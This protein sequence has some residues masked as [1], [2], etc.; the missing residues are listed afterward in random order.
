MPLPNTGMNFTALDELT[1]E[2]MN[3]LVENI[4]YLENA[5]QA[6][7]PVGSVYINASV[8]TNPAT[9]LGFGTWSAFA[10]GRVLVGVDPAQT[11]FDTLGETGGHKSLQ[12]HTHGAGSYTAASAGS[13]KHTIGTSAIGAGGGGGSFVTGGSNYDTSTTGSHTHDI[14]GTSS[15]TGSGNA[16]NL[17]PY[18]TVHMWVRTA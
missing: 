7:Y 2:E 15:S 3:D 14:T 4:E 10:S 12:A 6:L 13:H 1:A 17:Q 16:Q 5:L 8:A 18:I 11:E 9:L